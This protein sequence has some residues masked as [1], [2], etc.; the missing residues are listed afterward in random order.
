MSLRQTIQAACQKIVNEKIKSLKE[1]LRELSDGAAGEG[2][3]SAGD[4]HE[5]GRAM[6]QLEQEKIQKQLRET[7]MQQKELIQNRGIL[8]QTSRGSIFLSIPL[9][10]IS[11][12]G[13]DVMVISPLSPL[14]A[15]LIG[16]KQGDLLEVNGTKYTIE[17]TERE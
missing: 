16:K 7:E 17:K 5:T 14:G 9:G 12:E 11:V 13:K 8:F 15:K 2:K 3:S 1:S 10:K 6:A 4:K